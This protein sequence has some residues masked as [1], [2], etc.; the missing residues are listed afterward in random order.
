MNKHLIIL[1]IYTIITILIVVFTN[2][3]HTKK[4]KELKDENKKIYQKVA[5]LYTQNKKIIDTIN[6]I[7]KKTDSFL[8]LDNKYEILYE[9]NQLKIKSLESKFK[10]ISTIDSFSSNDIRQYFSNY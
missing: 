3:Y 8:V 7:T 2:S 1:L 5:Q 6:Q 4:I 10:K 9:K